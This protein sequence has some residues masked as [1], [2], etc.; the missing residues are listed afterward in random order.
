[1]RCSR[2]R[3][4][5]GL[6]GLSA[7]EYNKALMSTH[8]YDCRQLVRLSFSSPFLCV[9]PWSNRPV[10]FRGG[11]TVWGY[12]TARFGRGPLSQDATMAG[13]AGNAVALLVAALVSLPGSATGFG[14]VGETYAAAVLAG[15]RALRCAPTDL[16]VGFPL[17][18]RR[19]RGRDGRRRTG[20]PQGPTFERV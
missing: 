13:A 14:P 19:P 17:A 16:G 11:A 8:T 12:A 3:A 1:L 15:V 5:D 10:R 2:G 18:A 6:R 4:S 7:V 20:A 9:R